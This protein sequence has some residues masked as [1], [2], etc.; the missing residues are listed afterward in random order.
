VSSLDTPQT[1]TV[2]SE[3][4]G[5]DDRGKEEQKEIGLEVFD[6]DGITPKNA[7]AIG[8]LSRSNL[9]PLMEAVDPDFSGH[10]TIKE[11]N[12]FTSS[13]PR[14]WRYIHS[15]FVSHALIYFYLQPPPVG[16]ILDCRY[17]GFFNRLSALQPYQMCRL[18]SHFTT[19]LLS[20]QGSP[21]R[22]LFSSRFSHSRKCWC[23]LG[24]DNFPDCGICHC[25]GS[26]D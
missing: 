16:C 2:S 20:H 10:V 15:L 21:F 25:S 23:L 11:I 13:R 12:D 18:R 8:F 19:I 26:Y 1:D 3:P 24:G 22:A 14:E 7:W 6:T 5:E 17:V 4:Q 9:S